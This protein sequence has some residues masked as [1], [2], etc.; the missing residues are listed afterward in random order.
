MQHIGN[1]IYLQAQDYLRQDVPELTQTAFE[2]FYG[3]YLDQ[4]GREAL[5]K[6]IGRIKTEAPLEDNLHLLHLL[7]RQ[8]VTDCYI[9]GR[10]LLMDSALLPEKKTGAHAYL[11]AQQAY[12]NTVLAAHLRQIPSSLTGQEKRE[13]IRSAVL[14]FLFHISRQ[15]YYAASREMYRRISA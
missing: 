1:L 12:L 3:Q 8:F 7:I 2:V 13:N 11:A 4:P 5:F 9:A 10:S 6:S 15:A 14:D